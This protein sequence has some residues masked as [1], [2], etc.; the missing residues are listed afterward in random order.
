ME[1][2]SR[3]Q[4]M[5]FTADEETIVRCEKVGLP[6][7]ASP[8]HSVSSYLTL[9]HKVAALQYHNSRFRLLFRGQPCDYMLDRNGQPGIHSSLYPSVLRGTPNIQTTKEYLDE[10]FDVLVRAEELL[11][12]KLRVRDI[13]QNQIV[14]WAILQH[15]EV[16]PTPLLDITSSLQTAMTFAI[17]SGDRQGFLYVLAFPQL[18]GSI[19]VPVESMTQVIDLC[20]LCP[21]EAKAAFSIWNVSWRLSRIHKTHRNPWEDQIDR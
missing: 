16:C 2:L 21:P 19:S 7:A 10:R 5:T 3:N 11:K 15:Y 8:G 1:V 9:L 20:H 4:F 6:I 17:G 18:T 12:E 13:H 14:R